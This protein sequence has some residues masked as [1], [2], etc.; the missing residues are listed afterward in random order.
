MPKETINVVVYS[1][2]G[3]PA[4]VLRI[5]THP[6]PQARLGEAV[7][8]MRA[9]PINPA[10]LNA[11]EGK[12]PGKRE[13]PAVPGFEGAGF[14]RQLGKHVS[15]LT[16]GSLVILPHD[17]GTWRG[18]A[19]PT[20]RLFEMSG[21]QLELGE[22]VEQAAQIEVTDIGA[23]TDQG[24][25]G[26]RG[27]DAAKPGEVGDREIDARTG[28][29]HRAEIERVRQ[30]RRAAG[31]CR[32]ATACTGAAKEAGGGSEHAIDGTKQVSE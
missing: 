5:E 25:R 17:V 6:W 26:N 28:F 12:Y 3:N 21:T 16:V 18:D 10:D 7:I 23:G 31:A 2:H 27:V 13:V 19:L 4:D 8:E 9:A 11:I 29:N 30:I 1:A 15:E 24:R 14:V 20:P 32:C 22:A